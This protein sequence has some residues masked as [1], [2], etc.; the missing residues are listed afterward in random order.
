MF[1]NRPQIGKRLLAL[2]GS[3]AE[4]IS[5]VTLE[6]VL[7]FLDFPQ[8]NSASTQMSSLRSTARFDLSVFWIHQ[9]NTIPT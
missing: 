5:Y 1:L 3:L 2:D 6:W 4:R 8:N 7:M 9:H